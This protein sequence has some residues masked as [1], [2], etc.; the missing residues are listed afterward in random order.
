MY[1]LLLVDDRKDIIDAIEHLV[2]W[3]TIG[4]K[5]IG[6]AANGIEALAIIKVEQPHIM[7]TDVKMPNMDGL[8]LTKRAREFNKDMEIVILSGYDEFDYAREAMSLGV[9]DYLLKP[10]KIEK[11][12]E[13]ATKIKKELDNKQQEQKQYTSFK[14]RA[15]ESM[16]LLQAEYFNRVIKENTLDKEKMKEKIKDLGV[17]I[18]LSGFRVMTLSCDDIESKNGL[19]GDMGQELINFA[20]INIMKEVVMDSLK[21][22]IFKSDTHIVS[23]INDLMELDV[24][25]E[26][27]TKW[28]ND[29]NICLK[30]C[31]T[32]GIGRYYEEINDIP[33]SYS[34]AVEAMQN[35]FILGKN[36]IIA[37]EH[38]EKV[39][40]IDFRVPSK[41]LRELLQYIRLGAVQKSKESYREFID[42]FYKRDTK[43]S[44]QVKKYLISSVTIFFNELVEEGIRLS[45][46][47]SNQIEILDRLEN[48]KSLGELDT[49]LEQILDHIV[50]YIYALNQLDEENQIQD[51]VKYIHQEYTNP[52]LS[53]NEIAKKFFTST[54][55]LS[56]ALKKHLGE[57]FKEY[58][59]KLRM[60]KAKMIFTTKENKVYEVAEDVGYTDRRYFSDVFK[61]YTGMTPKEYINKYNK[62]NI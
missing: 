11:L 43:F 53:L 52:N 41:K 32:I 59:T 16:P 33:L 44:L 47:V 18:D 40:E 5:V 14:R 1:K 34:E 36:N 3:N 58:V 54:S 35:N 4:I 23:I 29:I 51:I 28:R 19:G 20:V 55:Y 15:I 48:T 50:R 12:V 45:E 62:M 60:E 17:D 46:I 49:T 57:N 22:V 30:H 6:K 10:L 13:L 61:K 9:K 42:E 7:I 31:V 25:Y 38:M 26:L 56:I 24:A 2:D 37:I 27:A 39:D 8:E 21:A